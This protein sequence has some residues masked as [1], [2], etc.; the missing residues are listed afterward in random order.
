[1]TP[2]APDAIVVIVGCGRVGAPLA[3]AFA[4]RGVRVLGVDRDDARLAQ[5]SRGEIDGDDRPLRGALREALAKKSIAFGSLRPSVL[6]RNFIVAVP[7]PVDETS[8]FVR[9]QLDSA[10]GEVCSAA[11]AGSLVAIRS[12]VPVGTLRA[13]A[14]SASKNLRWAACP[15][16]S[17]AGR[18]FEEQFGIP[19][20]IGG[21]DEASAQA[22]ERL[23]ANL[24]RTR[25]VSSPE[26]AEALKLFSN[27]QR[28]MTFAISNQFALLC[29]VLG[30][31]LS[32]IRSAG[33]DGF[34][35]FDIPRPGPVG[36]PCLTKDV[37]LL[38]QSVRA[39]GVDCDLLLKGRSLNEAL[40][41]RTAELVRET[42]RR[43]GGNVAVV[44]GMGFKGAP[45]VAEQSESFGAGLV[46]R[47]RAMG[48]AVRSW[49]PVT[50][51]PER[52]RP[53]IE[54]AAAIVLAND[55][56]ALKDVTEIAQ[57]APGATVFDM[58]GV[59][60]ASTCGGLILRVFGDCGA[61]R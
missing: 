15:D 40:V 7:T 26:A 23:F 60:D 9:E 52:R 19:H 3:V 27:V 13:A 25:R 43:T 59:A 28:D 24:G 46:A 36:G 6:P 16:R 18:A 53:V 39:A 48:L 41:E 32:E 10:I 11:A 22:A 1:M 49:D 56:P 50:D 61:R 14:A 54:G 58:C 21:I 57:L 12:T 38:E 47:L 30:L 31:D 4:S 45:A 37:H 20:V 5:L 8:S 44:L 2:S 29:E 17:S 34:A 35:R 51:P 33:A 55:H 42:L